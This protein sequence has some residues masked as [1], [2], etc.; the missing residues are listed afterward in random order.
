MKGKAQGK[1]SNKSQFE[2]FFNKIGNSLTAL[3]LFLFIL[4]EIFN[5][6]Y[7]KIENIYLNYIIA[8]LFI[9]I[10]IIAFY[11]FS[12]GSKYHLFVKIFSIFVL[13]LPVLF[14]NILTE[15]IQTRLVNGGQMF[16]GIGA[17]V[18]ILGLCLFLSN[19]LKK[20]FKG[21]KSFYI[22]NLIFAIVMFLLIK[23][24]PLLSLFYNL[25]PSPEGWMG[26][27][28]FGLKLGFPFGLILPPV[29]IVMEKI[30]SLIGRI[31][32]RKKK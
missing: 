17:L 29:F 32:Y 21:K 20:R 12:V 13:I 25:I 30:D 14:Y 31:K 8:L 6:K 23:F 3:S 22:L 24:T 11:I 1:N 27:I 7:I 15:D 19:Q 5:S 4:F 16:M 18:S 2:I 10:L 9:L 26:A 28:L